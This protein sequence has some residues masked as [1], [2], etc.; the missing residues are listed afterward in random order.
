MCVCVSV[1]VLQ[2][3]GGGSL[4]SSLH[5]LKEGVLKRDQGPVGSGEQVRQVR[6]AAQTAESTA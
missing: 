6:P 5:P 3:T 2:P 4:T 1:G